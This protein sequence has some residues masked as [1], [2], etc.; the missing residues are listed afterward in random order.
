MK[1]GTRPDE[2]IKILDTLGTDDEITTELQ[3]YIDALE[4]KQPDRPERIIA[5]LKVVEARYPA[6]VKAALEA[7]ILALEVNQQAPLPVD[8]HAMQY[9]PDNLPRWS[10]HRVVRR[11]QHRRLRASKK[12]DYYR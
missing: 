2:I 7:Y 4:M 6:E 10:H 12:L 8:H 1:T 5:I 11:E 9:D 3:T